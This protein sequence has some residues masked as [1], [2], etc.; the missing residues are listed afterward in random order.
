MCTS[1]G[2]QFSILISRIRDSSDS[3]RR[4]S[5]KDY[6]WPV[7][8]ALIIEVH[9]KAPNKKKREK[10]K[11]SARY[12]FDQ[13]LHLCMFKFAENRKLRYFQCDFFA[14]QAL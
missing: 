11:T 1:S 12:G 13:G 2:L 10:K 3:F 8:M 4:D 5:K 7:V 9:R 6:N 14:E